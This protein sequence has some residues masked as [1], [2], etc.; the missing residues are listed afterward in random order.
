MTSLSITQTQRTSIPHT[1]QDGGAGA[2]VPM[3]VRQNISSPT[4]A[5]L[6]VVVW[7]T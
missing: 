6:V 2:Q 1:V 7:D 4:A 3:N 5:G